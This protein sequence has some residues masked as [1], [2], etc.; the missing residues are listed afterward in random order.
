MRREGFRRL[1][2]R[3]QVP[4]ADAGHTMV[5]LGRAYRLAALESP[6]LY[7]LM[8]GTLPPGFTLTETDDDAAAATFTSL[9]DAITAAIDV[10]ILAGDA[11]RIALQL[12]STAHG[13]VG[14]ELAGMLP[15]WVDDA[16]QAYDDALQ[17]AVE[18]FLTRPD[19]PD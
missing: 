11:R 16:A 19:S 12:W 3:L 2:L 17:R 1:G 10:G 7:G 15:E 14:I 5:E 13:M 9:V 8:F 6:H 4:A 18:P